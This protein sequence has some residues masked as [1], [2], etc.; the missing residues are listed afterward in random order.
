MNHFREMETFVLFFFFPNLALIVFIT[1][2]GHCMV[3]FPCPPSSDNKD[4]EA[5]R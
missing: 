5:V 2:L 4:R 3:K 1:Y